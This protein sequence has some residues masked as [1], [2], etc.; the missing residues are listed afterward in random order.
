[1]TFTP[2]FILWMG[3][4]RINAPVHRGNCQRKGIVTGCSGRIAII[5]AWI[6]TIISKAALPEGIPLQILLF[7]HPGF[8]EKPTGKH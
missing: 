5:R 4:G 8:I 3:D 7:V 2:F 6:M 1:M